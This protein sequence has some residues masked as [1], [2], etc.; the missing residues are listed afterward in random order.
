MTQNRL[1][2]AWR[3]KGAKAITKGQEGKFLVVTDD[4]YLLYGGFPVYIL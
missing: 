4:H 1:V 2:V 3:Q